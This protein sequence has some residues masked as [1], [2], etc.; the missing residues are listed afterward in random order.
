MDKGCSLKDLP[1]PMDDRNGWR[2]GVREIRP[3]STT[4]WWYMYKKDLAR[5]YLKMVDI[6]KIISV[7]HE[8]WK[9]LIC[10]PNWPVS[11]T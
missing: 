1:E 5:N 10:G 4:W 3:N 9:L 7:E 2:K 11:D 6:V 8:Y